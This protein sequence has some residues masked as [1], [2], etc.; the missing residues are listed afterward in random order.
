MGERMLV[1][2]SA[3]GARI[4]LGALLISVCARASHA[5]SQLALAVIDGAITDSSLA[6]LG[7]ATAWVLGSRIEVATGANGR[8]RIERLP[9]GRY[10]LLVR[11]IGFAPVS[12][13]VQVDAGDTA[14]VWFSLNRVTAA[15]DT[16]R[17]VARNDAGR[18]SEF[19]ARRSF[20]DGQF[21]TQAEIEKL[22]LQGA[23]DLLRHFMAVQITT[24]G[25][26]VNR[27]LMPAQSCPFQFYIDG[28]AIPT[29]RLYTDLPSPK[30]IAGIEVY[31]GPGT[32][33]L[34]YKNTHGAGFCGVVLLWTRSGN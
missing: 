21:M 31:T 6:P 30:E 16:V 3:V 7:D 9:A 11:R 28:V 12:T 13:A 20:G 1:K 34:Q 10:L 26:A 33:P 23:S 8:F 29:P 22:N 18:L 14:R 17:V 32:I 27:R 19:E 25:I 15:L 2:T 5:Q 24:A 4:F